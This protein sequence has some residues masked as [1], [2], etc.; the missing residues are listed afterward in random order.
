[1][2]ERMQKDIMLKVLDALN[3]TQAR[4]FVAREAMIFGH[5]GE[6]SLLLL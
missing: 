6:S 5:G 2:A 4:W 1:M 3:E